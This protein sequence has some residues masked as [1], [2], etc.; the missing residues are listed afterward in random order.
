MKNENLFQS[1]RC[2]LNGIRDGFKRE[3]NFK[4][5]GIIA[6]ITLLVNIGFKIEL[7]GYALFVGA[8]F[9][10]F[11]AE[12]LNSAIEQVM[13]Y[14]H[15]EINNQI[16]YIKDLAAGAVLLAGIMFFIIEAFII[17]SSLKN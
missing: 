3:R 16:K 10:V 2:A 17:A 12:M 9:V 6:A 14:S 4:T 8:T 13:D 7:L 5:Y 15:S 11:I 1:I